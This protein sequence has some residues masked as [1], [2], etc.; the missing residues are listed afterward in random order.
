MNQIPM[1]KILMAI[2][3]VA[4][5]AELKQQDLAAQLEQARRRAAGLEQRL[6]AEEEKAAPKEIKID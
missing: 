1:E 6:K 2:G 5:N 3:S 4:L